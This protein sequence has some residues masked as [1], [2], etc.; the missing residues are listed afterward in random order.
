LF[1][2]RLTYLKGVHNL[3]QAI[4]SL[5][6]KELTKINVIVVGNGPEKDKLKEQSN[7]LPINF[8]GELAREEVFGLMQYTDIFVNPSYQ[9]GLPTTVLEAAY[10]GNAIIATEVGET[11]EIIG[12]DA[13]ILISPQNNTDL[14][15]SVTKLIEN[16][17]MRKELGIKAKREVLRKFNWS[18]CIGQY[19]E[20]IQ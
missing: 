8:V 1:V 13:G 12:K 18:N 9:E 17:K 11:K 7:N 5:N 3:V 16:L 20:M 6:S 4:K 14:I 2:G 10:F 19:R 15:G